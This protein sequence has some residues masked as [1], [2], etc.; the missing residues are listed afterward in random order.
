MAASHRD[1]DSGS[2]VWQT[3]SQLLLATGVDGCLNP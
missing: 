3:L 2:G 1:T